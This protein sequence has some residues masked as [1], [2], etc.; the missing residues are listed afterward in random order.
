MSHDACVC[1]HM[2]KQK[3]SDVYQ[4]NTGVSQELFKNEASCVVANHEDGDLGVQVWDWGKKRV[5]RRV[6]SQGGLG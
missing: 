2:R 4:G 1:K 5:E 3:A 6:W